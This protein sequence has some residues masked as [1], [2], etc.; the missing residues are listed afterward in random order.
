MVDKIG[1]KEYLSK[2]NGTGS[3]GISTSKTALYPS[4]L[5]S[6]SCKFNSAPTASEAFTVTLNTL[7]GPTY[8]P[9]LYTL[10]PSDPGRI[11][12]FWT[13]DDEV[14]LEPGDSIDVAYTNTDTRTYGVQI[15]IVE[16]A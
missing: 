9:L 3:A 14:L 8:D 7:A 4:E 12:I 2:T 13:P 10:D 6:V 5:I 16:K 1:S 15:T 11:S